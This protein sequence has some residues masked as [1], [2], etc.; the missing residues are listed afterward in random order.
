MPLRVLTTCRHANDNSNSYGRGRSHS[1][2]GSIK[3]H[4]ERIHDQFSVNLTNVLIFQKLLIVQL[5][6][7]ATQ[8]IVELHFPGLRAI[9][10][11]IGRHNNVKSGAILFT[12]RHNIIP[13]QRNLL[14]HFHRE[15]SHVIHMFTRFNG[16]NL[17]HHS[18]DFRHTLIRFN[19][20]VVRNLVS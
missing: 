7:T 4:T 19:Q 13:R 8:L 14:M 15:Y 17:Y 10:Y 12:T 16:L 5:N 20:V 3:T 1:G 6:L 18:Q 11:H 9:R 2:K